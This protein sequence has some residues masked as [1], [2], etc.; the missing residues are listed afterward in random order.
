ML[1]KDVKI[2]FQSRLSKIYDIK[3]IDS[4]LNIALEDIGISKHSIHFENNYQLSSKQII[5]IQ[6]VL[7]RLYANEP[8]QYIRGKAD[9]YGLEFFV[10]L[11]VLIPRQET[12]LLV[13][14]I[15]KKHAQTTN[16]ILDLGT[17]SGVIPITIK[18][19][20]PQSKMYAI[21]ISTEA[22]KIAQQNALHNSVSIKFMEANILDYSSLQSIPKCDII[23]SNPPYICS[24]EKK[25]MMGNV[26]DF[27]PHIALF[28]PD[29]NPLL[30]YKAIAEIAK[31]KLQSNGMLYCEINESFGKEVKELYEENGFIDCSIIKDLQNKDRFISCRKK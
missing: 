13:D 15:I 10:S 23:V 7:E 30:F 19:N 11:A 28:V 8:I 18:K 24:N 25:L 20:L 29:S 14:I 31:Q 4:I 16:T 21:D 22:L 17:G 9:F 3:E 6:S 26:L 12:E 27:E 1:L 2:E 5:Q